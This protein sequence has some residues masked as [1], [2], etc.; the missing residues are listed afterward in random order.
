MRIS[1]WSSDVCSSDL[2]GEIAMMDRQARLVAKTFARIGNRLR[3]LIQRVQMSLRIKLFNDSGTVPAAADSAVH[4]DTAAA[5][6]KAS[7]GFIQHHR[8]MQVHCAVMRAPADA[9]HDTKHI[10]NVKK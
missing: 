4:I 10:T 2:L 7:D 1:D 8:T 3:V 6:R 9:R 5:N